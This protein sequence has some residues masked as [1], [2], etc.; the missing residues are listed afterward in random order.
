LVEELVDVPL[1]YEVA[2]LETSSSRSEAAVLV[3]VDLELLGAAVAVVLG[4]CAANQTPR[5]RKD[6]AL[7]APVRRRARRAGWG[8]CFVRMVRACA[9]RGKEI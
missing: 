4:A 2:V 7:T 1:A 8:F 5:P 6:A 9:R 3:A